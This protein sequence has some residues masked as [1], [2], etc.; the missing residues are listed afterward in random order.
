MNRNMSHVIS[1]TRKIYSM[2]PNN[3][4]SMNPN[5]RP[6][7]RQK[8]QNEVQEMYAKLTEYFDKYFDIF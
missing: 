7:K 6:M 4:H 8:I 1:N 3:I 2:N 5:N